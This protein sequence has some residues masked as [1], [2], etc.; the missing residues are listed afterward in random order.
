MQIVAHIWEIRKKLLLNHWVFS[1][2]IKVLN[3]KKY[4]EI[5]VFFLL[6][7]ILELKYEKNN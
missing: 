6:N 2:H 7:Y 1:S 5:Y 3:N 4:F